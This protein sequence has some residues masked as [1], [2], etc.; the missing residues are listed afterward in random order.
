MP[1]DDIIEPT[2]A[3]DA[4]FT[5][6]PYTGSPTKV[7]PTS[8]QAAQGCVPGSRFRSGFLNNLYNRLSLWLNDTNRSFYGDGSDGDVTITAGTTTL[9]RDM[10][11]ENL[12]V[13]STGILATG[14]YRIF[15]RDLCTIQTSGLIHRNGG[16][17]LIPANSGVGGVAGAGA[18]GSGTLGDGANGGAGASNANGAN[19]TGTS[20]AYGGSGGAGG[21]SNDTGNGGTGGV[22]TAPVAAL[23]SGR[24][25]GAAFGW[26]INT[27]TSSNLQWSGGAGGAGGGGGDTGSGGG[28][29][30]GGGVLVL[31]AYRLDNEG[32]IQANGGVG[33]PAFGGPDAA[34]N[35]G[36][37]GGGGGALW[38]ITRG[39]TGA[40][41]V[42][43][44]GGI[45]GAGFLVGAAGAN[46]SAG[47]VFEFTA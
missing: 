36:G 24:H 37:G 40:G 23:G 39:R 28:G 2:W 44:S 3:S 43:A 27:G 47:T 33:G 26:T 9:T 5:S 1:T 15:V 7:E 29:G 34:G 45:G 42:T 18:S 16:A 19:G 35:G 21:N 41:T 32:A 25:L 12:T 17:G 11:Y 31:A 22:A 8:G 20:S 10:F 13:T 6:G 14:G 46:G 30:G 38:L 4:N